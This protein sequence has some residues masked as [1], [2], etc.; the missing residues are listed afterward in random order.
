MAKWEG[1]LPEG[2]ELGSGLKDDYVFVVDHSYFGTD[3]AYMNG[4]QLLLIWEGHDEAD[5]EPQTEKF[6]V[7]KGWVTEDLGRTMVNSKSMKINQTSIYGKILAWAIEE[8]PELV[9]LVAD[10]GGPYKSDV[11][12]GCK[13]QMQATTLHFGKNIGD[14]DRVMPAEF[15][16]VEAEEGVVAPKAATPPQ[17]STPTAPFTNGAA[18]STVTQKILAR[19]A[20]STDSFD[21]F[22]NEA[23]DIPDVMSDTALRTHVSDESEAGFYATHKGS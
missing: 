15:L 23:L 18:G 16:G 8:C 11:W 21:A 14:K 9:K 12:N 6:S 1:P 5:N 10:R 4:Q 20:Q 7:G 17:R 3:A 19:L 22:I 2:F 13:F